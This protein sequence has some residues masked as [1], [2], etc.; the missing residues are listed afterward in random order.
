MYA[1]E[2][3]QKIVSF[4]DRCGCEMRVF[5]EKKLAWVCSNKINISRFSFHVKLIL[6]SSTE[7]ATIP[8]T[9]VL[10]KE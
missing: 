6:I 7:K 4:A 2:K 3:T 8:L 1:N 5:G 10:T 9:K